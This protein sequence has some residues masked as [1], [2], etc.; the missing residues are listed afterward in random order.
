MSGGQNETPRGW[1]AA[2]GQESHKAE[3]A[4]ICKLSRT[5]GRAKSA[6]LYH[7]QPEGGEPFTIQAKGRDAWTLDRLREA[8]TNGCTPRDQP[9]PRWSAYVFNLRG[10]GVPIETV[11]EPHDGEF[12]GTH[13]RYI[14]RARVEQILEGKRC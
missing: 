4:G 5:K 6:G 12:P 8:G 9:A 13:A 2:T 1:R 3:A 7:I 11:N 14:L 10:L